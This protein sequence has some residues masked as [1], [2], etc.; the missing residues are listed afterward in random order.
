MDYKGLIKQLKH[1][2]SYK[3]KYELQR[4]MINAA[5]AIETLLEERNAAVNDLALCASCATCKYNGGAI[6][7][8]CF[9]CGTI[10]PSKGQTRWEWRGPQK[11]C[12]LCP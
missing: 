3:Q 10:M 8:P 6:K 11:E 9:M 12:D 7:Q 4:T 5:E 1:C 2:K